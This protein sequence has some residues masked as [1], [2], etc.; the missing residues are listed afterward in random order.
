MNGPRFLSGVSSSSGNTILYPSDTAILELNKHLG[1]NWFDI[2]RL[3]DL[4]YIVVKDLVI[5]DIHAQ[6]SVSGYY[7]SQSGKEVQIDFEH[8]TAMNGT[9]SIVDDRMIDGTRYLELDHPLFPSY[10]YDTPIPKQNIYPVAE[11]Q[12]VGNQCDTKTSMNS[13]MVGFIDKVLKDSTGTRQFEIDPYNM[14]HFIN[15]VDQ[16]NKDKNR[17]LKSVATDLVVNEFFKSSESLYKFLS[18][19]YNMFDQLIIAYSKRMGLTNRDIFFIAKGGNT[20]RILS[21]EFLLE[22]PAS[23]T[24]ELSDFYGKFFKRGDNDFG[25]FINPYLENYN[26]IFHEVTLLS[27]MM[28]FKLRQIFS[29]D[30]SKYFDFFRYSKEYQSETL[31]PYLDQFNDVE[32]FKDQF[33]DF[34]IGSATALGEIPFDYKGNSDMSIAFQHPD[35]DWLSPTRNT[36]MAPLYDAD[37]IMTITHNNALD[38]QG[39]SKDVRIKFN[40]TRTK[41]IFT[42]LRRDGTTKNVGGELIDVGLD[43]R[44]SITG[45]SF[46]KSLD[47]YLTSYKLVYK[48]ICDFRF[49]AYSVNYLIYDLERILF[50]SVK[51]PWQDNKYEKRVNRVV[52]MHFLNIFIVLENGNDKLALIQDLESMVFVPISRITVLD[53]QDVSDSIRSFAAKYNNPKLEIGSLLSKLDK[54]V[55]LIEEEE[56]FIEMRKL[57]EVLTTNSGF[58]IATL[59]KIR[60]FCSVSGKVKLSDVKNGSFSVFA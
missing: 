29:A 51:Y 14:E 7:S 27:Y 6:Q 34:K 33:V 26:E 36:I 28:Q 53:V 41:F 40:L 1:Q 55:G 15:N 47:S 8:M 20:L 48:N 39:G 43:H 4:W 16:E 18:I 31:K 60:T 12:S 59:E 17:P 35:E 45:T 22:L 42:L 52:Y 37:S 23:A 21:K 30:M 57:G 54:I 32:D 49:R 11:R 3:S 46:F 24:R 56:D 5:K 10:R 50:V 2:E 38:F 44:S 9:I 19:T 25:V 58:I 13:H